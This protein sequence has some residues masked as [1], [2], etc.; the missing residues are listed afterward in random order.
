MNATVARLA[1]ERLG[2]ESL[3]PGQAEAVEAVLAGRDTLAVMPTG[4][5]K[6][7]IYQLAAFELPGPTV[8]VSPLIALQRD[9]V[10]SIVA[11]SHEEAEALNSQLSPSRRE[12]LFERLGDGEL[13]F[14]LLAPEQF[15]HEGT[16]DRLREAKPSLLV[17]DEAHC[18]SE[19]GHDFRPEY[20]RLGAV[21]EALGGPTLLALTAT[22]SPPVREE[23]VT[24][25]RMRDPALVVRG[26]DRPNIRLAVET[27]F[28]EKH[29]D[30]AVAAAVGDA[31]KPG[32]VYVAT[33]AR[34]EL[35]AERLGGRPYHAGLAKHER[36]AVQSDFMADDVDVVVATIAF[37]MGV[38]KPN[39]RFVFHADVSDSVDSYYQEVGRAGRDGDPAV[40]TLFYRAEDVGLRHFFAAGGLDD[41]QIEAV[42]ETV[43]E[44]RGSADVES[45]RDETGLSDS[46]VLAALSRLEDAGVVEVTA[47]GEVDAAPGADVREAVH[48][49]VAAEERRREFDRSRVEMMRAYA[50]GTTCRRAYVLAYFGEPF[51]PPCGNCDV[52]L[53]G[54]GA[55]VAVAEPFPVGSRVAHAEWGEGEVLR[56]ESDKVVVLF[57]EAGYKTLAVPL[58]VE[59][60]LLRPV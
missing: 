19:W 45:V 23:I 11:R 25:L 48:E 9:Q 13:E 33:R 12:D 34:A 47:A 59:R 21:R 41:E 43:I 6:S 14:V 18:V 36:D 22:A 40:A 1:A 30:E 5:G 8:V 56:Y 46:K 10:A 24:R 55:P 60:S 2:F 29:K 42:A 15:A 3:R 38:D 27:F 32:I 37:G 58:V 50:E 54:G 26:F 4:S 44:H 52:C 35:L 49:A 31:A 53:A 39:V 16:L 28:E 51:E 7:A 20:L 17:V 57:D